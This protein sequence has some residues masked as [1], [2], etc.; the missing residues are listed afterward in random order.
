MPGFQSEATVFSKNWRLARALAVVSS[1]VAPT[2]MP[3]TMI[4]PLNPA[5]CNLANTAM[6]LY[7]YLHV[8]F[9][10]LRCGIGHESIKIVVMIRVQLLLAV[11]RRK[12]SIRRSSDLGKQGGSTLTEES[13]H[14]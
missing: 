13:W 12:A 3:S 5:D 11:F 10:R 2:L 7:C 8:V 1:T 6:R 9:F 4:G 14:P